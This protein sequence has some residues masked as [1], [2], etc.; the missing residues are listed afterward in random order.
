ME[1]RIGQRLAA[2]CGALYVVLLVGGD[3][4]INPAGEIPEA[5][6]PLREVTSYLDK[7]DSSSFWLGRSIGLLGLCALLVFVVY[8]S[9]TIRSRLALAAGSVAVALQFLAAPAQF[10]AVQGAAQGLDPEVARALLHAS[11]SFQLSFL[12]LA[13]FLG[14]VALSGVLPRWLSIAA[15]LIGVGFVGGMVGH[16]ED[17]AVIAFMAFGLS[18]LW[19]VAA[20]VVLV[21][22][23]GVPGSLHPRAAVVAGVLVLGTGLAAC[24][25]DEKSD[26]SIS[27]QEY[28]AKSGAICI[29]NGKK[30]GV[31]YKRIVQGAPRTKATAQRFVKEAVVPIFSDSVSRRAALPAPDGDEREIAALNEEGKRAQAEFEQI[32]ANSSR[33]ADLMLGKIPDPAKNYDARSRRYGIAKCGGDQS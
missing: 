17:P 19:F 33:S 11:I 29:A 1:T 22:R 14:A 30:A 6:A 28:V 3:D 18:L 4:F 27:K 7:A 13:V 2:A 20:S 23:A 12:P 21:R 9:R 26:Q 5:D 32:A 16:P 31:A 25:N 24:G 10:A 8:V 15:G